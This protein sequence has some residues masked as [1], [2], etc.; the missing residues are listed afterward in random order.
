MNEL[1]QNFQLNTQTL[2]SYLKDLSVSE[3]NTVAEAAAA[4]N[5]SA[6][7]T[8]NATDYASLNF[9]N[10]PVQDD[11]LR[12][13]LVE[14]VKNKQSSAYPIDT[15]AHIKA[16]FQYI[17]QGLSSL[18]ATQIQVVDDF[19]KLIQTPEL[20]QPLNL[21]PNELST[22]KNCA[23]NLTECRYGYVD[24]EN[25]EID[26]KWTEKS[27][28]LRSKFYE[29]LQLTDQE[30]E[31][32]NR[33]QLVD[34]E[35]TQ[36]SYIINT[37]IDDGIIS[38]QDSDTTI[39]ETVLSYV[40]DNFK[41]QKEACSEIGCL[42]HW[43]SVEETLAKGTGDCEDLT[44]LTA[45][46]LSNALLKKGHSKD[47]VSEMVKV[48]AGYLPL[49]TN[50]KTFNFAHTVV[51]FNA[52]PS[53]KDAELI[54]E[55]TA[56]VSPFKASNFNF[57]EVV[58][59][60]NRHFK[61]FQKIDENFVTANELTSGTMQIFLKDPSM[62]GVEPGSEDFSRIEQ[63][64][65]AQGA[66]FE[67]ALNLK[68][69]NANKDALMWRINY[70]IM[71]LEQ[72]AKTPIVVPKLFNGALYRSGIGND[73][74]F[75]TER[76]SSIDDNKWIDLD[77]ITV[78]DLQVLLGKVGDKIPDISDIQNEPI[79]F[80]YTFDLA[81]TLTE[82]LNQLKEQPDADD[83]DSMTGRKIE[84]LETLIQ[85][86][87][88]GT[89]VAKYNYQNSTSEYTDDTQFRDHYET[90][91]P[92]VFELYQPPH[93]MAGQPRTKQNEAMAVYDRAYADFGDKMIMIKAD[94][95]YQQKTAESEELQQQIFAKQTEKAGLLSSW[96][97]SSNEGDPRQALIDTIGETHPDIA[98][99]DRIENEIEYLSKQKDD[100]DIQIFEDNAFILA[101]SEGQTDISSTF[102]DA[103]PST[104]LNTD[105][106]LPYRF[107]RTVS[108]AE[109]ARNSDVYKGQVVAID[110]YAELYT[111]LQQKFSVDN[112]LRDI[113]AQRTDIMD[114]L[115]RLSKDSS[116]RFELQQRLDSLNTRLGELQD[117]SFG[118]FEVINSDK[119]EE[120][121]SFNFF[122]VNV[123][124]LSAQ[125]DPNFMNFFNTYGGGG[126][127][128]G[129]DTKL[130]TVRINEEA[131]LTTL[132]QPDVI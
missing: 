16:I 114:K 54:L 29:E 17:H 110:G 43:Q 11:V 78:E 124:E 25:L 18:N 113:K 131:F 85:S 33:A 80:S 98:L 71:Q 38:L 84:R 86:L 26:Q 13:K 76:N 23:Q 122:D 12:Y 58:E 87:E 35:N 94:P 66:E 65:A 37:L 64:L 21:N 70:H 3:T 125:P 119:S 120:T 62:F 109:A 79:S 34:V 9:P 48:S 44:L 20:K 53:N 15:E 129:I 117:Q 90:T 126:N 55:S 118:I 5:I 130:Q 105:I 49:Q 75:H 57:S 39:A 93:P 31:F 6:A 99:Y 83:S 68:A 52:N 104:P 107:S 72:H 14:L 40:Q 88:D 112:A 116:S 10:S 123:K 100:I 95:F 111:L 50:Q 77:K 97:V 30:L 103:L 96:G 82:Q 41:Y 4:T 2:W 36:V 51:K 24:Q 73:S 91:D 56:K 63:Q 67:T 1:S 128:A 132:I 45:S 69:Y 101:L 22:I 92:P 7:Q 81:A 42:D 28:E 115:S 32:R 102:T 27:K 106:T 74:F 59:F 46:L 47:S 8:L 121:F 108:A 19:F 60:N 61:A 89:A 127:D